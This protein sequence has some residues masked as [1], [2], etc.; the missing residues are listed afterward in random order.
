MSLFSKS[1]GVL[2]NHSVI[3][4]LFGP[5][6]DPEAATAHREYGNARQKTNT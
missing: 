1:A 5:I 3:H 2:A 6:I 4:L